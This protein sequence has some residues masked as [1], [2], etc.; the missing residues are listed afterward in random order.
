[1]VMV[2]LPRQAAVLQPIYPNYV[3]VAK[4]FVNQSMK[5]RTRGE[6]WRLRG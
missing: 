2:A 4:T 5:T 1:M 6:S 3:C